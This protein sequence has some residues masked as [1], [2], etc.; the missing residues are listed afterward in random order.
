M[1]HSWLLPL[2]WIAFVLLLASRTCYF[3]SFLLISPAASFSV[4]FTG[5]FYSYWNWKGKIPQSW[6]FSFFFFICSS[7]EVISSRVMALNNI[8]S[9]MCLRE[10]FLLYDSPTLLCFS[11]W[12]LSLFEITYV[13]KR[14]YLL[15]VFRMRT[16]FL[17]VVFSIV[18]SATRTV[19]GT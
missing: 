11:S 1:W 4:A 14:I 12:Q 3:L 5:S 16:G 10:V 9:N 17:S 15:S 7:P 13:F 6:V 18:S 2:T 19:P 8:W